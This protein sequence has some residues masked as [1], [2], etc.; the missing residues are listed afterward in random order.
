MKI[1]LIVYI[2]IIVGFTVASVLGYY[3]QKLRG[4]FMRPVVRNVQE[5]TIRITLIIFAI[6]IIVFGLQVIDLSSDYPE[7]RLMTLIVVITG[8]VVVLFSLIRLWLRG[9]D[10]G[11]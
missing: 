2:V 10:Y 5:W 7:R 3:F 6:I 4:S 9:M 8:F 11:E 1:P